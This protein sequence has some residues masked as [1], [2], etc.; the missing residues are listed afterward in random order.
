MAFD[1]QRID[2]IGAGG[3]RLAAETWGAVEAP[4]VLLLHG[5][6][7]RHSWRDTSAALANAGMHVIAL[8]AR[9]HGDS[10]WSPTG[11]YEVLAL[12]DDVLAV[13]DTLGRPVI[14]VGASMGGLTGLLVA[15][16]AGPERVRALAL[17]DVVPNYDKAGSSRIR[18]FMQSGLDGFEQLDDAA[19]AVAAYL[20]HRPRPR[21]VEGLRRNLR[22]R[23]DSRWYWH[24]DPA[25]MTTRPTDDPDERLATLE[26]AAE[27]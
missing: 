25:M 23:E 6:Q 14:I 17:I 12:R 4:V 19:E 26:Q 27:N 18:T 13:L 11:D 9:G 21:S 3:L 22:Q 8:D 2:F 15:H 20:P 7:H 10:E 16:A 24:W 1:P 5:G